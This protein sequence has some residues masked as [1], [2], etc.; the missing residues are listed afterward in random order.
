MEVESP[1]FVKHVI[2]SHICQKLLII[3]VFV[4][5][6]SDVFTT[7]TRYTQFYIASVVHVKMMHFMIEIMWKI[8]CNGSLKL[9]FSQK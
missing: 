5:I 1:K 3:A 2:V 9:K 8:N 4:A 6:F 7:S